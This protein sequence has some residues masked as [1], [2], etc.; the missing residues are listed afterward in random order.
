MLI[1]TG[2]A[3]ALFLVTFI[4]VQGLL[5][6]DEVAVPDLEDKTVLEAEKML[7]ELSLKIKVDDE[8]YD[9]EVEK[10]HIISQL[11]AA[12]SKVKEGREITVV[13]SL[14]TDE[15]EVPDLA[16]KTEQ[17][18]AIALE[19]EELEL[20]T[21]TKVT[22]SKQPADVV[23]YQ[24]V[25]AGETVK[26]GTKVDIMINEKEAEPEV[27]TVAVPTLTGKTLEEAKKR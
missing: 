5:G 24:S 21:V 12:E 10:D 19:N 6:R 9:D 16:G 18:A 7:S 23:V 14:G 2:A 26:A 25:Q 15:V 22:D 4:A 13:V 17:E 3:L 11:P 1:L 8:V 27:V 20:G